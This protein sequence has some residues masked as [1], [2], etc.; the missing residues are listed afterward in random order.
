[1]FWIVLH[2]SYAV[3]CWTMLCYTTVCCCTVL[4]HVYRH[5]Y[6]WTCIDDCCHSIHVN[7]STIL[8]ALC[9]ALHTTPLIKNATWT[10]FGFCSW[11]FRVVGLRSCAVKIS[12]D[13]TTPRS[14][15]WFVVQFC[16]T[17]I[18]HPCQSHVCALARLCQRVCVCVCA[19]AYEHAHRLLAADTFRHRWTGYSV[20]VLVNIYIYIYRYIHTRYM[21][22]YV[23]VYIYIYREREI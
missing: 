13:A 11:C 21:Y 10:P 12:V 14:R 3:A 6:N 9:S 17:W 4:Y 23:C 15:R 19:R 8:Y 16:D 20:A 22:V 7:T 5:D 1:M 2:T 18:E